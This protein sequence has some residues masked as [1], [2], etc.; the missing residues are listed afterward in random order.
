VF[1]VLKQS[2]PSTADLQGPVCAG[3]CAMLLDSW[4]WRGPR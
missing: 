4:D 1:D 3:K 2:G